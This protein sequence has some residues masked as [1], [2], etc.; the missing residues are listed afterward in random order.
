VC[1]E[2]LLRGVQGLQAVIIR[3]VEF[4]QLFDEATSSE[5]LARLDV[6]SPA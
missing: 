3:D 5:S 6:A 2:S 1:V 4:R